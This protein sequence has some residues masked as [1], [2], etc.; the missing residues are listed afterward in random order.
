MM[1]GRTLGAL[2]LIGAL[3]VVGSGASP[4]S[5]QEVGT[6]TGSVC[7]SS[8]T[9]TG[10]MGQTGGSQ[11]F[12]TNT[13]GSSYGDEW[14]F[15]EGGRVAG[16][17][18][19]PAGTDFDLRLEMYNGYRDGQHTWITAASSLSGTSTE[20]INVSVGY[21]VYRFVVDS[22]R[23]AG[24]FQLVIDTPETTPSAPACTNSETFAGSVV[25]IPD[26]DA[27]PA[28]P[29]DDQLF[30]DRWFFSGPG[31][32]TGCVVG[33]QGATVA[34]QLQRYNSTARTYINIATAVS[35][36]G[37]VE[38]MTFDVP[39]GFAIYR[40]VDRKSTRLNSS[41]TDISRMPSSA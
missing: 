13:Y 31:T 40:W 7:V 18:T 32:H 1:Y 29:Y 4:A 12:P 17:L 38:Q 26:F 16:C 20:E 37:S 36:D 35:R 22:Y 30:G 19:G 2:A 24:A 33:G 27:F 5:A 6:S 8:E 41:H 25:P 11:A 14:F 9:L 28:G 10:T 34:L 39:E 21:G 3:L 23:G 15:T